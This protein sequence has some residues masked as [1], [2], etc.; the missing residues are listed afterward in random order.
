VLRLKCCYLQKMAFVT[1]I[2]ACASSVRYGDI[3]QNSG[4]CKVCGTSTGPLGKT[5]VSNPLTA[6]I[7]CPKVPAGKFAIFAK[8]TSTDPTGSDRSVSAA[9]RILEECI[10]SEVAKVRGIPA[11]KEE[12][13]EEA[14]A[15]WNETFFLACKELEEDA[16]RQKALEKVRAKV[17]EYQRRTGIDLLD[18]FL[19][20]RH[21]EWSC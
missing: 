16:K 6:I 12:D 13:S 1:P 7:V 4:I 10:Q 2:F 15:A 20:E 9:K 19:K 17:Q 21:A 11:E 14:A 3:H 5:F 18:Q 8:D